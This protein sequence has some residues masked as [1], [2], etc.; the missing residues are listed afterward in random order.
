MDKGPHLFSIRN[1]TKYEE[2]LLLAT[3]IGDSL[4]RTSYL[5]F[6]FESSKLFVFIEIFFHLFLGRNLEFLSHSIHALGGAGLKICRPWAIHD[7]PPPRKHVYYLSIL[8]NR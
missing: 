2:G 8:T 5:Y 3:T 6:S 7:S 1:K 4:G